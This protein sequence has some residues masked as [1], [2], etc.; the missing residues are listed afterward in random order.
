[1]YVRLF[2][3]TV[4][5]SLQIYEAHICDSVNSLSDCESGTVGHLPMQVDLNTLKSTLLLIV[6]LH[7]YI[8]SIKDVKTGGFLLVCSQPHPI[9]YKQTRDF[10][11]HRKTS[12]T[13]AWLSAQHS[14]TVFSRFWRERGIINYRIKEME[15]GP[16]PFLEEKLN[17]CCG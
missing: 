2:P 16:A 17:P 4:V 3:Q 8:K 5:V 7:V 13:F 9:S 15:R 10:L 6:W 14:L 12:L 1:M 11:C